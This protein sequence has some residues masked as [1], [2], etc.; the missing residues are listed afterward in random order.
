MST[1]TQSKDDAHQPLLEVLQWTFRSTNLFFHT[2]HDA[3][4][5]MDPILAKQVVGYGYDSAD[6]CSDQILFCV[7]LSI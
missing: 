2:I 1:I 4:L 6:T 5:W 7:A 3:G